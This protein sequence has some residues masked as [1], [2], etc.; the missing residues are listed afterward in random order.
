MTDIWPASDT[1]AAVELIVIPNYHQGSTQPYV[2]VQTESY[3]ARWEPQRPDV[4]K[5]RAADG[6][7]A[8]DWLE[9]HLA[10]EL[11][12]PQGAAVLGEATG[13][14]T[15][16][17]LKSTTFHRGDRI[18]AEWVRPHAHGSVR[19]RLVFTP[20]AVRCSLTFTATGLVRYTRAV[21]GRAPQGAGTRVWADA[22]FDYNPDSTGTALRALPDLFATGATWLSPAPF[23]VG[24]QLRNGRWAIA[25]LE[26]SL[27]ALTFSGFHAEGSA[28]GELGF[29]ISYPSQPEATAQADGQ[30]TYTTPE[31]VWRFGFA[32]A[33]AAL[34]GHVEGLIAAGLAPRVERQVPAWHQR[35]MVCGWHRQVELATQLKDPGSKPEYLAQLGFATGAASSQDFARQ[36]IYEDHLA[37]Y[38]RAG[39]EVGTVTIDHGWSVT[40]GDWRPDPAKWPDLAGFVSAQHSQGRRVLLWLCVN[41]RGLPDDELVRNLEGPWPTALDPR[42]PQWRARV[43]TRLNE[44]LGRDGVGAD[45]IKL[46]FTGPLRNP[47]RWAGHADILHGYQWLIEFY[48]TVSSAALAVRPDAL[49]DFQCAHPQF[50]PFHTMTRLND[51]FLPQPQALRVM[52][53]RARI[54]SIASQGASIDTDCPAGLAYLRGSSAFGNQSLYLTHAQLA[55][56]AIVAAVRAGQG[57]HA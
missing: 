36:D 47:S 22:A 4:V 35:P 17:N 24:F 40:E 32:D 19:A 44:L 57:V 10:G 1:T 23:A 49:L 20:A 13:P 31:L 46:D 41:S 50:A 3:S 29:V 51:F 14:W 15:V 43:A 6:G 9:W 28:V 52:G 56:P 42:H 54:A 26:C 8:A 2:V 27:E 53:T 12:D 33:Y 38:E 25:A 48:R 7:G 21:L 39:I 30:R 55:D 37:A 11:S 34:H 18:T 5:I 16:A 45:G